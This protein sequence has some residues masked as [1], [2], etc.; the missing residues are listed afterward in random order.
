MNISKDARIY[1]IIHFLHFL[2]LTNPSVILC[3]KA[4]SHPPEFILSCKYK[5]CVS[6]L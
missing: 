1:G 4:L 3:V 5:K 6:S 2:H